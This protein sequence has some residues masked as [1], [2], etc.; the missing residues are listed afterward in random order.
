MNT[1]IAIE[2]VIV[3]YAMYLPL[4]LM[5]AVVGPSHGCHCS[6][7]G[8]GMMLS[9]ESSPLRDTLPVDGQ[10][11]RLMV[12]N[13]HDSSWLMH[14]E[15][16]E[17]QGRANDSGVI[18]FLLNRDHCLPREE[19]CRMHQLTL[20]GDKILLLQYPVDG[21]SLREEL[22]RVPVHSLVIFLAPHP[23]GTPNPL[24]IVPPRRDEVDLLLRH[25]ALRT[26]SKGDAVTGL[27]VA[28]AARDATRPPRRT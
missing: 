26:A 28:V 11:E 7:V 20:I 24:G 8:V 10:R 16:Q 2:R 12:E 9:P 25:D 3:L 13:P 27:P 6:N 17:S 18:I 22:H 1:A 21:T 15:R 4:V 23:K 19:V 14:N 5:Y